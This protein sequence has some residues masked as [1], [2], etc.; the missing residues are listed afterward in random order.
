[1]HR[2]RIY[3]FL[4]FIYLFI[5]PTCFSYSLAIISMVLI[6]YSGR[7]M[8]IPS[9]IRLFTLV[10]FSSN[11]PC[12]KVINKVLK[13]FC[14]LTLLSV[15]VCVSRDQPSFSCNSV[16]VQTSSF[17]SFERYVPHQIPCN[18]VSACKARAIQ[19]DLINLNNLLPTNAHSLLFSYVTYILADMFRS[20]RII[21]WAS[22]T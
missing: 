16:K 8:C 19:T 14:C 9:K 13:M 1:M 5:T 15:V 6:W 21:V 12:V 18:T 10:F 2:N 4:K 22:F 17:L 20:V 7:T 3:L 11:L